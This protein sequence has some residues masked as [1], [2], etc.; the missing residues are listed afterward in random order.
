MIFLSIFG[1]VMPLKAQEIA[2]GTWQSHLPFQSAVS[3]T[4]SADQVY[5]ASESMVLIIDKAERSIER[6]DKVNGLND[7]DIQVLNYYVNKS[8]LLIAYE[9]GNIDILRDGAII[10]VSDIKRSLTF[11]DKSINH[12]FFEEDF[13]Y[14]STNF[15]IVKLDLERYEVKETYAT[16][17]NQVQALTIFNG[18]IL[19]STSNGIFEGDQALNLAD[20][21]NWVKHD[22]NQNIEGAYSSSAI[23]NF[24]EGVYAAVND[25]LRFYDG[26]MWQQLISTQWN[27]NGFDTIP[28]FF[29]E[30]YNISYL[31]PSQNG[32]NLVITLNRTEHISKITLYSKINSFSVFEQP[33]SMPRVRQAIQDQ[34]E[35]YWIADYWK[36][37]QTRS[38]NQFEAISIN[39]PFA[40]GVFD[41][42]IANDEVWVTGG[43]VENWTATNS[44][45]GTFVQDQDGFWSRYSPVTNGSD[46]TGVWDHLEVEQHPNGKTY[47]GSFN[48]GLIEIDG[49]TINV[50]NH[51]TGDNSLQADEQD[52]GLTKIAGLAIDEAGNVWISNYGAARPISVLKTD[53]TWQNFPT[54]G[55]FGLITKMVIDRNGYK[56]MA[57]F[58]NGLIVF[59]EGDMDN[60]SDDRY[61]VVNTSTTQLPN[62]KVNSLVVDNDG[63]V[64]IGTLEGT[65]VFECSFQ[66]F[67]NECPGRLVI[68]SADDFG[69]YL[70]RTQS[71][72]AMAI[73]GAN[74]KWFGTTNGIF[75][76]SA[77][78]TEEVHA[79]NI[80]NS[81][82]F[83]NNITA[84]AYG[85]T[86]GKMYIG[87][88]KGMIAYRTE[89]TTGGDTHEEQVL[90]FPN[91]VL[92]T[93]AGPIAIK[94]LV[95]EA[96][97]KITDI[98]GQL[99]YETRALGGQAIWNGRDYTGRK[100]ASGVYLVFSTNNDGLE[101]MVTKLLFLN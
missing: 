79:F 80:N 32:E 45:D 1:S 67:D 17:N 48:R 51:L 46:L 39:A 64:W 66:I 98:N 59:D 33:T 95:E 20:F 94:G 53:G 28:Q 99:M 74:R 44:S 47:I 18:H 54:P 58:N 63:E 9:N 16:G 61:F 41:I 101:T 92:P 25:T 4:Q 30:N 42:S 13:A 7:V 83:S 52:Q 75:V 21:S 35:T 56:W 15:G 11:N 40:K 38:N 2:I 62:N 29:I 22:T 89:T 73:D 5:A 10:N 91:P 65:I 86:T 78:G 88:D 93:Y 14:I 96:N 50:Y 55:G 24:N 76:Q 82:L 19:A 90:A 77:D 87:T 23:I 27:G 71:I 43:A 36:G 12:I 81:P 69:D 84:L 68:V 8:L 57:T 31:T 37:V 100:A 85:G 49:A 3:I 60:L 6:L 70:L 34:S 26:T 72:T 97:V